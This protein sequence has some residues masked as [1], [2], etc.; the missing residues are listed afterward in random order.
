MQAA[1]VGKLL[2]LNDSSQSIQTLSHWVQFH[3][4]SSKESAS[5]WGRRKRSRHRPIGT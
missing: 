4:K 1:Y 5:T 3:R 2:K